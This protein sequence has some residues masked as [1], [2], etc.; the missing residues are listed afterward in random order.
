MDAR[1]GKV[2]IID[3]QNETPQDC[4]LEKYGWIVLEMVGLVFLYI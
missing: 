4:Q 1:T 2:V 3:S